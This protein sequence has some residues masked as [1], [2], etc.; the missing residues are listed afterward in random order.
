MRECGAAIVLQ[1][2]KHRI[3]IDLIAGTGQDPAA[4]VAADIVTER[5]DR[6]ADIFSYWAG[7]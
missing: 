3:G 7:L 6:A 5:C 4:V 1:W 2:A